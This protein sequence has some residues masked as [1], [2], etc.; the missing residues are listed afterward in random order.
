VGNIQKTLPPEVKVWRVA[1][2]GDHEGEPDHEG[3][4]PV[5]GK[6]GFLEDAVADEEDGEKRSPPDDGHPGVERRRR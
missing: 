5:G 1:Q 6:I 2:I 4:K 3:T